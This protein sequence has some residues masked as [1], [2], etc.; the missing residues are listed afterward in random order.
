MIDSL[1]ATITAVLSAGISSGFTFF[2]TKKKY[3]SEVAST[4]LDN[5]QKRVD[6]YA[7]LLEDCKKQIEDL[8]ESNTEIRTSQLKMQKTIDKLATHVCIVRGCSLREY[9]SDEDIN[10]LIKGEHANE[11]LSTNANSIK[12]NSKKA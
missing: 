1:I 6:I 8:T 3:N 5:I 11:I 2:F 10:S 12:K 7:N 4:E 9:L